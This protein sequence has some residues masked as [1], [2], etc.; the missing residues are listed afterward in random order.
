V[1]ALQNYPKEHVE[2][3]GLT[4]T[5]TDV[6]YVTTHFD[7]TLYLY[8]VSNGLLGVVEYATDLFDKETINRMVRNFR[9]LLEG[10]IANPFCPIN[11]LS[12]LGEVERQQVIEAFNATKIDYPNKKPVHELFA[13]QVQRMPGAV[14]V[15]R[16]EQ[17]L[18][19]SE[20]DEKSSQL[21]RY[22]RLKGIC[23]DQLVGIYV[24]RGLE[25]LVGML[26]ILKAGG[27]YV[28][29]DPGYPTERLG[30]MLEDADPK[31]ILTQGRLKEQLP[32]TRSCSLPAT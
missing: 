11:E 2:L 22:L 7:L 27:A 24:E 13:E 6:E 23:T 4:W 8:E 9:A 25:M 21:A 29:L 32:T 20:L 19:Y 16:E 18:T 26:G 31:I 30:R 3:A 5:L 14:A 28:P 12:L 17:S 1:L 15:M 10:I